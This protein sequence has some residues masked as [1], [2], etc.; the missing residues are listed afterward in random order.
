MSR[1]GDPTASLKAFPCKGE[2]NQLLQQ[3]S[4]QPVLQSYNH[5]GGIAGLVS[6]QH[7]ALGNLRLGAVLCANLLKVFLLS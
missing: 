6:C 7:L 2:T 1:A 4:V 5:L 3:L